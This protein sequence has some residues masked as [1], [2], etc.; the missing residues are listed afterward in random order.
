[1]RAVVARRYGG[2]EALELMEI[3]KPESGAGSVL[4]RVK[5]AGVNPVDWHVVAGHLNSILEVSLPLVP[6]FDV[7]GVIEAV[8]PGVTEFSVGDEVFGYVRTE[9]VRHGTYAE[10]VAAPVHTLARK[11]ASLTWHQAAGLPL[12]GLTA[13][14][15]LSRVGARS[16][17]TVLVHAAA[18]GVGSVAVQIAVARGARVIGTAGERNHEFLRSLGAEP[19]VYGD[20][21]AERVRELAPEG[22]DAAVDCVGGDAVAVSQELLKDPSRVASIVDPDVA[23]RGGHQVW[24]QPDPSELAAL[25]SLADAG[26]LTVHIDRVLPLSEAAEA[27]R[28]SQ[29]GR[30][31]GKIVLEIG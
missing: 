30:V 7:A 18:G 27:F 26:G 21:L 1:M 5:A 2:P 14:Q 11:P 19:V 20:G 22:V 31:R 25:A 24:T 10:L 12:V 15:S 29:T 16:E 4:I 6:G 28:L 13:L 23:R 8:G 9:Q 17:E 3:D